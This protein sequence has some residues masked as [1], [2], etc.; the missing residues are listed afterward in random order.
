MVGGAWGGVLIRWGLGYAVHGY[1]FGYCVYVLAV[2]PMFIQTRL[3]VLDKFPSLKG[4]E[5]GRANSRARAFGAFSARRMP[6]N[7]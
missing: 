5:E 6:D 2:K 1:C 7:I 4:E 3:A